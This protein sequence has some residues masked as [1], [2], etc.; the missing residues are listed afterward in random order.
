MRQF[1]PYL[2]R[3][4]SIGA[5]I[6]VILGAAA[7]VIAY[8]WQGAPNGIPQLG[9]VVGLV[10]AAVITLGAVLG[11]ILPWVMLKLGFDHAPGAD[12]FITTIKDFTGLWVYFTLVAWLVGVEVEL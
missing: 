9:L 7:G 8:F 12:P 4:A 10:L 1:F 2:L 5:I 6:G 11:A 3:E